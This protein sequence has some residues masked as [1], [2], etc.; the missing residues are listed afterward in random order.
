[1]A[2]IGL[3]TG[4]N[5][6]V[7]FPE[8]DENRL[9]KALDCE[10]NDPVLEPHAVGARGSDDPGFVVCRL[11]CGGL[12]CPTSLTVPVVSRDQLST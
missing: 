6:F 4:E 3:A 5:V 12:A 8:V 11:R 2:L 9:E 10:S 1:M 7:L